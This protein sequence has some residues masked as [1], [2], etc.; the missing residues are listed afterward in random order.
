[1]KKLGLLLLILVSV[2]SCKGS[3][4]FAEESD[5]SQMTGNCSHE[6]MTKDGW[7]CADSEAGVKAQSE[8]DNDDD[9]D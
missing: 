8:W 3:S 7:V 9:G 4:S 1:M 6:I 2:I 5:S